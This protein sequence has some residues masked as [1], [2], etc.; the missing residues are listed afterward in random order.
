MRNKTFAK[1]VEFADKFDNII[2]IISL[3]LVGILL[4]GIANGYCATVT[5]DA[6]GNKGYI[7]IN[8]GKGQGHQGTW[9][10]IKTMPE[11][12]GEKG[13]KGDKGDV[14]IDGYT[15]IKDIDYFDGKDGLNGIDGKDV[16][17]ITVSNLKKA[18]IQLDDKIS[19]TNLSAKDNSKK[20]QD[21]E[22]RINDL[23]N[24]INKLEQTQYVLETSFRILDT[25]RITLRPFFRQNFTKNK[26]D[27]VGLKIDVKL[28]QS[29]EEKLIS[30]VNARLDLLEKTIGN[31]PVIEKVVDNKGNVKS[32]SIIGNGLKVNGGF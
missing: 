23:D 21:H 22:N 8:N 24:R 19:V 4:F 18:D 28:G 3:I 30:K 5:D 26:V 15:P 6:K 20:I 29:Y 25:K 2:F 16:D 1:F 11:L 13:D 9:T 10:D 27:V 31:A 12:K 14:G 17:P 32:I 7:L